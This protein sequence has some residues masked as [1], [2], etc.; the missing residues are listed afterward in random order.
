MRRGESRALVLTG[1]AGIGK[2]ALLDHVV[3]SAHDVRVLRAVGVQSEMELPFAALHQLCAPILDRL[4]QLPKPQRTALETVFGLSHGEAPDPF[5]VGL[6]V[7]GLVAEVAAERPLLCVVDDAQWL[8]QA[9]AQAVGFVAR[10]LQAESVALLFGARGTVRDLR[11]LPELEVHGLGPDDARALLTSEVTFRSDGR[12][13]DQIVAETQGNPLALLELP[14]GLTASELATGF[15]AIGHDSLTGRIE[16]TFRE[17]FAALP[18]DSQ[19]FALIAAAEPVGD[20]ALVWAAAG[21]L[22]VPS[23]AAT[24]AE[25]DHLVSMT[26]RVIFRHP[27]ARSAIYHAASAAAR[28]KVHLTLAEVSD[29]D[30]NAERRAWHLAAA[31]TGPDEAVAAELERCA[32]R[33]RARGGLVAA[34]AFLQRALELTPEPGVRANRALAAA[35]AHLHAGAFDVALR[36][37]AAAESARLDDLQ[38]AKLNLLRGQIAFSSGATSTAPQ[39]LLAAA[40]KLEPLD[41]EL[42]RETYLN[43]WGAAR[44]ADRAGAGDLPEI[45][46]AVV[47]FGAPPG[48]P[49]A[50]DHLLDGLTLLVTSGRAAA[51]SDL[52]QATDMFAR[53]D[54]TIAWGW[55]AVTAPFLLWDDDG[56]RAI[57][58]R[59]IQIVRDTG[60]L[61]QLPFY[62]AALSVVVARSGDL[63]AA[64]ALGAE[65]AEVRDATGTSLVAYGPLYV[66][67]LRGTDEARAMIEAT[68]SRAT[69]QG[70]GLAASIGHWASAVLHN[71]HGRYEEALAEARLASPDPLDLHPSAWALPE[72]IEAAVRTGRPADAQ[73]GLDRLTRTTA[74]AATQFARGVEARACALLSAGSTAEKYYLQ[75][76]D[77]FSRAG[78][79]VELGRSHLL[80]GEWLRRENRRVDGRSQLR[81][82]HALLS[83]IGMEAFAERARRELAATGETV[84]KRVRVENPTELT[85]QERQIA[86]LA[87]SGLTNADIGER[88]FISARTVEWHLRKVFAK[89]VISSRKDLRT[90]LGDR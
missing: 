10:R 14:R 59:Q 4:D 24:A 8:D 50:M 57:C 40:R 87:S 78:L 3:A 64:E 34:A 30:V 18:S 73:E 69:E 2:T 83:A 42:A 72:L 38:R 5:L 35:E 23:S 86:E 22:G 56:A 88:L 15:G 7:L 49:R 36:M 44:F 77:C 33:A 21:R 74:P 9:S 39:L 48:P 47:Q 54:A 25:T 58:S 61:E 76:I 65:G 16:E 81:A 53:E 68:L 26:E 84:R 66:A 46:R 89:L 20:A 6:A 28:R 63:A 55:M 85:P 32:G 82:A 11:G 27:L 17:R 41:V 29:Q 1:D 62:L 80:Y 60:A 37:L 52:R 51:A 79:R 45:S 13:L 43:A 71:G 31:A 75:A 19:L 90:A 70:Q 67:S 12:V